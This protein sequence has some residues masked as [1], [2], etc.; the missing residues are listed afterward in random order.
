MQKSDRSRARESLRAY[1]KLAQPTSTRPA[2]SSSLK[3]QVARADDAGESGA[4]KQ[5]GNALDVGSTESKRRGN[6]LGTGST[7][8]KHRAT[9]LEPGSA[10]SKRRGNPLDL[11]SAGFESKRY[12]KK[13]LVEEGVGGL[14]RVDNELVR[15]VRQIDGEMKTMVYENYSKF[16]SATETIGKMKQ[17]ADYMDAEMAKLSQRVNRISAKTSAVNSKFAER[18]ERIQRLSSEHRLLRNLQCLFDLPEQLGRLIG[19]GRFVD[20]ART[21]ARTQPLLHH[22]RRLGAFA[23]VEKDGKEMMTG[24]EAAIG[25]RWSDAGTGVS[26]GAECASLL[27]LLRPDRASELSREYLEIQ[28]AKNRALRQKFLEEAYEY[29]VVCGAEPPGSVGFGAMPSEPDPSGTPLPGKA[30]ATFP[31][32][33]DS[34]HTGSDISRIAHFNDRYLPVWSSL[35]IGFASQFVS[36]A[37]SGLL[38]EVTEGQRSESATAAARRSATQQGRTM[39][40]LEATTEGT[41][42]GLLSP[43]ADDGTAAAAADVA[44]GLA[45]LKI[46]DGRGAQP[47]VGWQAMDTQ[48]LAAA[49][50][51][52]GEHLQ[53]WAAE[54]EFIVDSLVQLPDD[55]AAGSVEPY[56]QQLDEL[57][58]GI[59][60]YPILVRVGGLRDSVLRVVERWQRQLIEGVLQTI[61]RD[62]VERL[63]YYFDPT[64]DLLDASIGLG[65]AAPPRRS[66]ASRH[67]RNPS[68]KSTGSQASLSQGHQRSGSVMSGTPQQANTSASPAA[69]TQPSPQS[70]LMIHTQP[71]NARGLAH[72]RAVSS[73]F[74]ALSPSLPPF[75]LSQATQRLSRAST[76]NH[77]T[78]RVSTHSTI[79]NAHNTISGALRRA[80][81]QRTLS[82]ALGDMADQD[83]TRMSD[84][85]S[86]SQSLLQPARRSLSFHRGVPRRYRPWLIGSVNRT[87]PLHVF[88][89]E[90]ESWLIQQILERV[91]PLL[92]RV[93]QHYLDIEGSQLL[94]EG[95][96]D[97]SES[98]ADEAA[99]AR[100]GATRPLL[101]LQ[102]ATKMRQSFIKTLDESLD[103]WMSTWVPDAFLYAAL[104]NPVHGTRTHVD[105]ALAGQ[106]MAQLGMALIGDP[107]SSLLLARFAADFELTLTQSVYQLCEHGISVAPG[108]DS[109]A[110]SSADVSMSN[111]LGVRGDS[112]DPVLSERLQSIT[113][114][115]TRADS[116][117][118][119]NSRRGTF[120]RAGGSGSLLTLRL[121]SHAAKWHSVAERLVRNFVMTVGQDISADYLR[122]QSYGSGAGSSNGGSGSNRELAVSDVW[123]SICRWMKRVEDDTNALFYDPVFSATL[124]ALDLSQ[125]GGLA[126]GAEAESRPTPHELQQQKQQQPAAP[127]SSS[128]LHAH[129]LSNIDRLFAERVDVFPKTIDPLN[130]G[131]ILF[132]LAMQI[133]KAA[134]EAMRLR[135]MALHTRLE[136]Q[137]IIVDATFVR[138]WM[139]RYAGVM[140]NLLA[141]S[142]E[143]QLVSQ[144]QQQ[145]QL[146]APAFATAEPTRRGVKPSASGAESP[147]INERDA[148][149]IHNLVDDWINSAKACALDQTM[150]DRQTVD[151]VVFNAWMAAYFNQ[152]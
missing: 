83:D 131:Q 47:M 38:E 44:D 60:A 5:R 152:E 150:P 140:P 74:E 97:S 53:E 105:T 21:W 51:A 9:A 104:A 111:L 66:S 88:L 26:E 95:A 4:S 85:D 27:V 136:F 119:V 19:A 146:S 2:T 106:P 32:I 13:V 113:A 6:A 65:S 112:N 61:V 144:Q 58:G 1:Y 77:P 45:S 46:S 141:P 40:L 55:A 134:L 109:S 115:V 103:A 117:A 22:Y 128:S 28:G 110:L 52:F 149:A 41:V 120:Y 63:E 101:P 3:Q 127:V 147:A 145:P 75:G 90:T 30:A 57:V 16:I 56:L 135:P 70:P 96:N 124:K 148:Q 137:Q 114:S 50:Q 54:Y 43:L 133:I 81:H 17:D 23:G 91:N 25:A 108:N 8:S 31:A 79:P 143:P 100:G 86:L 84:A 122:M 42:V 36:P 129:I 71:S 139:L 10:D 123:L 64:I 24:V 14:L 15:A 82:S 92:E 39:S 138:A 67:Q 125:I 11:D 151:R 93:V 121:T 130:A 49:Q 76:I 18:R 72:A 132:C 37:G 33:P 7:D 29:P 68:I 118:S 12:L 20:A 107:V 35:V 73:A 48:E 80:R 78:G 142:A 59:S 102:S 87:A 126:G 98:S 62:M 34:K 89:A 99:G 94:D 69:G 116:I